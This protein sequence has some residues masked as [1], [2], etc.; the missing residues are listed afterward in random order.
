[1]N[2]I[3][4]QFHKHPRMPEAACRG[5]ARPSRRL[6]RVGIASLVA[7]L[8]AVV[9]AG[10]ALA[11]PFTVREVKPKVS[12]KSGTA[13][14]P[15]GALT[16]LPSQAASAP[17][18]P[19]RP[20]A[21]GRDGAATLFYDGFEAGDYWGQTGNPTWWFTS[22]R[23]ATGYYSSYCAGSMVTPP[24]YYYNGMNSWMVAGPF[25]LSAY[26]S[27]TF[28]FSMYF[29]T[30]QNYDW[31]WARISVDGTNF[32]GVG[33]SG[34]NAGWNAYSIDLTNVPYLGNVC[35]YPRVWIA[36]QFTSDA[37][38]VYEGAYVDDVFL[39][40]YAGGSGVAAMTLSSSPAVVGYGGEVRVWG[41]LFDYYTGGLLLGRQV[42]W[43]YSQSYSVPMN[44]TLGGT[45]DAAT[46]QYDAFLSPIVRKTYLYTTFDGDLQYPNGAAPPDWVI[47]K[48][49]A[50][51][52]P[53]VIPSRIRAGKLVRYWG[54]LLPQHTR[55]QNQ[56]SHTKVYLQRYS[57][58]K[59]RAVTSLWAQS[60]RNTNSMTEYS[61]RLRFAKG[62]WRVRAIHQDSD[63]VKTTSAYKTF[64]VY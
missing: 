21:A 34:Y 39:S 23:W 9:L 58:G 29:D 48:S 15:Q 4:V 1:M 61:I 27:G 38:N 42:K 8:A 14:A 7:V 20:S 55:E 56:T 43:W 33:W 13:V 35:G 41:T 31:V 18:G 3:N 57:G 6:A 60:Y 64:T 37:S 62:K 10:P 22:Y 63:H 49:S 50:W 47:V 53:P 52:R 32:A 30:E 11:S 17:A 24:G 16:E 59:W 2:R 54:K 46:G 5:R 19:V 45:L 40:G 25:D 26:S 44:W 28:D 36:F 51:L 12:V